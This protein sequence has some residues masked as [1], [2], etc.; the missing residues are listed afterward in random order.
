MQSPEF[1]RQHCINRAWDFPASNSGVV[2][3]VVQGH[4]WLCK[5][6]N[7]FLEIVLQGIL[8]SSG[9]AERSDALAS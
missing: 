7:G 8:A 1:D 3:L 5:L 2:G 9:S 4:P 6:T